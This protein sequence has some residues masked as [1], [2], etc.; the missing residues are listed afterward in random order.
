MDSILGFLGT[1][2]AALMFILTMLVFLFPIWLSGFR[3]EPARTAAL[4]KIARMWMSVFFFL[5]GIRLRILGKDKFKPGENYIVV[6]NHNSLMD[7]PL[8]SPGIPGANKTIAKA[9]MAKIPIFNIIYKRG[10]ILVDRK[11]DQSRRDSY[12]KMKEVLASGMHMCIYPEGTR[13]KTGKPLKEFHEGAFKLALDTGKPI[14][15]CI[16]FGTARM[17]PNNRK[18]Y[19]RPGRLEMHFLDPVSAYP[20]ET[21]RELMNRVFHIMWEY[22]ALREK[23]FR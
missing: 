15:P 10:S 19:F 3:P 21:S 17:L 2:W 6:S 18:Y 23:D 22:Y 7:V 12:Q 4:I 16:I 5:S 8:T 20:G 11:S 14:M 13:N 1:I 9:E